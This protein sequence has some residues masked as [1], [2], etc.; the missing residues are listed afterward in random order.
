MVPRELVTHISH[1]ARATR[2]PLI[3]AAAGKT[4]TTPSAVPISPRVHRRGQSTVGFAFATDTAGDI[5]A[6]E[7]TLLRDSYFAVS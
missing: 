4:G 6:D 7:I 3:P 5:T 1:N 2:A